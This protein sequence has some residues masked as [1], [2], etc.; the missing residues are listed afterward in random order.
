[1]SVPLPEHLRAALAKHPAPALC[2]AFSGGPDSTALLHALAQLPEAR[3][4]GLRALHVN[5]G[6]QSSSDA[7]AEHCQTFCRSL[8][9]PC[10]VL[11]VK[12]ERSSGVG[13]EAA[14]QAGSS[15]IAEGVVSCRSMR[16]LGRRHGVEMPIT[17]AVYQVCYRHLP[18]VGLIRMLM[19]RPNGPE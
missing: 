6:L 19:D 15:Q 5:H 2:V 11:R 13:L 9:L 14:L 12:V 10:E 18:P 8:Q 17:E 1:M 7:W 4:R 3:Q 16:D